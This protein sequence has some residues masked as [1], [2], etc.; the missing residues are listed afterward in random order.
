[1]R[2]ATSYGLLATGCRL[3]VTG[4]RLLVA[5]G[6]SP[7]GNPKPAIAV[8]L[9]AAFLSVAAFAEEAKPV[10][11]VLFSAE[12]HG[13]LLPCDC[14]LQLIGG[15]A[16]RATV[17]KQFR[18]RGPVLLVDA[19]NWAAGGLY[20]EE[21]DGDAERDALRT[22]LMAK[23]MALMRYD[24]VALGQ[25]DRPWFQERS[26]QR[27]TLVRHLGTSLKQDPEPSVKAV[28]GVNVGIAAVVSDAAVKGSSAS[29]NIILSQCGEEGTTALMTKHSHVQLAI[30]A[31]RKESTRRSWAAG[32]GRAANFD[33]Q[34][35]RL[36]VAEIF[37]G[38]GDRPWAVRVRFVPLT[39]EVPEDPEV[40]ALL[41]PHLSTLRKKGK[42]RVPVEVFLNAEC[43]YSR[44]LAPVVARIASELG[45]RVEIVPHFVVRK[46]PDGA[47]KA[48]RGARELQENRV[49]ALVAR[50][51]PERFWEWV[52]WRVRQ[53]EASWKDGVKALGLVRARLAGALAAGEAEALLEGDYLLSLR[54]HIRTTP[55]LVIG[56]RRYEGEH[57]RLQLLRVLCGLLDKPRPD[58]CKTVPACF[59]DAQCRHRGVIGR[60]VNPGTPQARCDHSRKAVHVPAVVLT[61]SA[62]VYQNHERILETLLNWLPG[63]EWRIVDVKTEEGRRLA[64]QI[65]P[66][67]YP[68]YV[69]DPVARTEVDFQKNLGD[70]VTVRG[71]RLVLKPTVSGANRIVSRERKPFRADLFVARFSR[72]GQEAVDVALGLPEWRRLLKLH[73]HDALYWRERIQPDGSVKRELSSRGGRAE[74]QEA[75]IAAAVRQLAPER[76]HNYLKERGK[77]RGSLFWDRAV[78]A[79]GV[80]VNRVR[81]LVEGEGEAGFSAEIVKALGAQADLLA[82]LKAGGDVVLLAEN[83]EIVPVRSRQELAQ[84]LERIA[85]GRQDG[86][87]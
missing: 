84:Y 37:K 3:L 15:V 64:A 43:P 58:V 28:G 60:C 61:E 29:F 34:V 40:A 56:N 39:K 87:E 22:V 50:Y 7:I 30:N 21:S 86:Q 47:F 36:G 19:G 80:D 49:Q 74:L 82:E 16:R 6:R 63:L 67:R 27:S 25:A 73:L 52:A 13:A 54:R 66:E 33:Y 65:E 81:K 4:C 72:V 71:G 44:E 14:P 46:T 59:S 35:Q 53:P 69:F 26:V 78:E 2:V 17:V 1:M 51:Y 11:T 8:A 55:T 79:A 42:R 68:A 70:V 18:K 24:V 76:F 38:S 83:C 5:G 23:T 62:M 20:D 10:F 31:G 57:F 85:L 75:A 12:A 45:S 41:K 9:A 32:R 48:P 77:R